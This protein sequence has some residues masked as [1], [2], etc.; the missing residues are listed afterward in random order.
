MSIQGTRASGSTTPVVADFVKHK[1][2]REAAANASGS[3]DSSG[4][5]QGARELAR[6]RETVEA[7]PEVRAEKVA[8]L[9]AAIANGTYSADPREIARSLLEK[10]L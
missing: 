4:I 9:K 6:A 8:A 3:S 5:T 1:A 2:S 7:S 10:G